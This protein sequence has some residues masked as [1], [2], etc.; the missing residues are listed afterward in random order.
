MGKYTLQKINHR[1]MQMNVTET[2]DNGPN[3]CPFLAKN[4]ITKTIKKDDKTVK[5]ASTRNKNI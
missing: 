3:S 5:R 2:E 1:I 4:K